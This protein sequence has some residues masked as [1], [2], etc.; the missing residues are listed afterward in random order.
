MELT[1]EELEELLFLVKSVPMNEASTTALV[2]KWIKK[3]NT[4][5]G[6]SA[7]K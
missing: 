2:L 5:V 7:N 4:Y 3:I 6:K 1:Q